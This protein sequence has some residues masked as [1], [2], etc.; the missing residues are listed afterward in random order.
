[1]SQKA[2]KVDHDTEKAP[3]R[4]A[5]KVIQKT[6]GEIRTFLDELA[7]GTSNYKSL[8]NLTEQVE[9]QYHGRF[10][11]EL[12]QNAHDA[13]FDIKKEAD[14]TEMP[15]DD[16][17]IE[18]VISDEPLFGALYVANDGSPFTSSNFDNLSRFGQSD[19][20]P[21]KH[22]GNKGI[23]F[24]SVLEITREPE[25]Y[26]RKE[27]ASTSFDGFTFR[28]NPGIIQSFEQPIQALLSGHDNPD[29][30]L[31][32]SVPL[33]DWGSGKLQAF[34]S[35]CQAIGFEGIASELR[36]LSPY[37]LPVHINA[38]DKTDL[39][40]QFEAKGFATV[41]RLPFTN[42]KARYLALEKIE[43]LDENTVLFLNKA[44]SLW[45]ETPDSKR[46]VTRKIHPLPDLGDAQQI[47]IDVLVDEAGYADTKRYWLWEWVVGGK[48]N[49]V[50]AE[51]IREAISV[52]K[53]PGKWPNVRQAEVALAVSVGKSPEKGLIS[54]FLPTEKP[55]G[56]ACHLNAPFYGD[57]SR[58]EVDL[59]KSF[60]KLLI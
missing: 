45:I 60:N 23:G 10:L 14:G 40:R 1:M 11:I 16:G 48:E 54:I 9:H 47:D 36:F 49:T 39:V 46:F 44:K 12:I 34:R 13:L 33:V 42:E 17:R 26:S 20:D 25:I 28:F 15:E 32:I 27:R 43:E 41:I 59:T 2:V 57:I 55:S 52:S 37:L 56:A 21:E 50:E 8:H 19:K 7:N 29:L 53:L 3:F 30:D 4:Y 6:I 22:I 24:R 38:E 18:I 35:R 51:E 58:T 5:E 31:G